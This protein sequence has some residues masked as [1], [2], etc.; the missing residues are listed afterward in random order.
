MGRTVNNPLLSVRDISVEFGSKLVLDDVHVDLYSH[1]LTALVGPNGAGKSTLFSVF[2]GDISPSSGSVD[3]NGQPLSSLSPK[4]LAQIRS[5]MPQEHVMRFSFSVEEIVGLARLSH[6]T[7]PDEDEQIIT[8]ALAT[9]DVSHLRERDVQT[10]SGGEMA[11]TA[12]ARTLAQ[13]TQIVLLD[14]P[15]AALDLKH[16]QRVLRTARDLTS[17][18]CCVVIVVH[19]LN[20]AA[21]YAD[22]VIMLND[23][24][25]VADGTP[26]EVL[27]APLITS[28]YG[29]NVL[30]QEHPTRNCPLIVPID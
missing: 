16:Q 9:A 6:S 28:I 10:L 27:Q 22:R 12:Y 29:Q 5:V 4:E 19:D 14:E 7:S 8:Q 3:I 25:I 11:R 20:L 17:E 13:T 23:G 15:T 18:G 21:A 30:C 2:S 1:Q 26:T 24:S